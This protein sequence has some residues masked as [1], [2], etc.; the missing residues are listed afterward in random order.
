MVSRLHNHA[1]PAYEQAVSILQLFCQVR[2]A[3][4]FAAYNGAQGASVGSSARRT[5]RAKDLA[6]PR[7]L[8]V[9][10]PHLP[11]PLRLGHAQTKC[12]YLLMDEGREELELDWFR[13]LLDCAT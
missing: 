11:L 10:R 2:G 13:A 1:A 8:P 4:L 9:D 5:H 7:A 3:R 12:Y 6:R